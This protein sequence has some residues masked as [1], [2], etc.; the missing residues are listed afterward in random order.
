[1]SE[2]YYELHLPLHKVGDD[3]QQ[4]LDSVGGDVDAG[5]RLYAQSLSAAAEQVLA[6]ADVAGRLTVSGDTH[7]VEVD[8]DEGVL[9]Q[10]AEAG[11]LTRR[12]LEEDDDE[13]DESGPD[14]NW[15]CTP[16][17]EI[18]PIKVARCDCG[19]TKP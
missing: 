12:P 16:C 18:N 19:R 5:L 2:H 7:W 6:V 11:V 8:G 17:G 4:A 14:V 9:A 10:L 1:M 15:I 3:V 13:D